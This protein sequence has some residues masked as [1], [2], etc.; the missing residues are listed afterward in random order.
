MSYVKLTL[1][2]KKNVTVSG[3]Y[4]VKL[5]NATSSV[6]NDSYSISSN[7]N[8][9][10]II[11]SRII[12][13]NDGWK[14]QPDYITVDN[15][16][17]QLTKK[18]NNNGSITL[19]EKIIVP[20][21]TTTDIDYEIK[22]I[23]KEL[24]VVKNKISSISIDKSDISFNNT[25]KKLIISGDPDTKFT[26]KL[27]DDTSE[28]DRQTNLEIGKNGI[29]EIDIDFPFAD[30][31]NTFNIEILPGNGAELSSSIGTSSLSIF[32]PATVAKTLTLFSQ[33]G[34]IISNKNKIQGFTGGRI[35]N[36]FTQEI[37]LTQAAHT[38]LRQPTQSD[39]VFE[40]NTDIV[41]ISNLKMTY[42]TQHY[43]V[44]ITGEV[45]ID[46]I[47]VDNKA[48]LILD[49]IIN[50][51]VTLTIEYNNTILG[52]A[53][54]T[55]Y[56]DSV[57]YTITGA[58]NLLA[59]SATKY[60]FT[61]TPASGNE[62]IPTIN[63]SDFEITDGSNVVTSTYALNDRIELI[64]DNNLLKVGFITKPFNLPSTSKTISIRPKKQIAQ[65]IAVVSD[66]SVLYEFLN[67]T[68]EDFT[69]SKIQ[70]TLTNG[71]NQSFL[72]Q[73]VF[74]IDRSK[75]N[76]F[77][78]VFKNTGHTIIYRDSE[79]TAAT[80]G[81]YTDINGDSVTVT[82]QFELNNNKTQLTLNTLA[83]INSNPSKQLG[84]I[85]I[86]LLTEFAGYHRVYLGEG[87][88]AVS[89]VPNYKTRGTLY[90]VDPLRATPKIGDYLV[91]DSIY[92]F[93]RLLPTLENTFKLHG[94]NLLITTI[95]ETPTGFDKIKNIEVCAPPSDPIINIDDIVKTYGDANFVLNPSSDSSGAFTYTIANSSVA[96]VSGDVV[97]IAGAGD[98]TI[99]V[100][101]AAKGNFNAGTKTISLKVRKAK[102]SRIITAVDL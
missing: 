65:T 20:S 31:A 98:T 85:A 43:K 46:N 84:R 94:T 95:K 78:Q 13:P 58:A 56:T 1:L 41:K 39:F 7:P 49:N 97:T 96:T 47:S 3:N 35:I 81:T 59:N 54:T 55:N 69:T 8:V 102:K 64:L 50:L 89:V 83:N 82:G 27:T 52:G 73:K 79:L 11:K 92:G 44:T 24:P 42:N 15:K 29:Y 32:R 100:S 45:E 63:A 101:Q 74:T 71:A 10:E 87:G 33:F 30:A 34:S 12:T 91:H 9:L 16:L 68:Q 14:L 77:T 60:L 99:K 57:D 22:V 37:Q 6:S 23:A 40:N 19:T 17:I 86:R 5:E 4:T 53:T 70:G 28:I 18:I 2:N 90:T 25:E 62:F 75:I 76:N 26:Y 66:F 88:C 93:S 67:Q 36:T 51:D 61:L 38:I 80:A 72:F 48:I 21:V